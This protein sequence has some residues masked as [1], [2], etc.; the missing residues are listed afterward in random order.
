METRGPKTIHEQKLRIKSQSVNDGCQKTKPSRCFEDTNACPPCITTFSHVSVQWFLTADVVTSFCNAG[1]VP[2]RSGQVQTEPS[3]SGEH[4]CGQ[5]LGRLHPA[6]RNAFRTGL[7]DLKCLHEPVQHPHHPHRPYKPHHADRHL[8]TDLRAGQPG[9]SR[10]PES[11][12]E[13]VDQPLLMFVHRTRQR[14][15]TSTW[16]PVTDA[17]AVTRV[18]LY[19]ASLASCWKIHWNQKRSIILALVSN[20]LS[21]I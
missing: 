6:R 20:L 15:D 11:L 8:C 1:L 3:A 10:M 9:R 16:C 5:S 19:D 2:E 21:C 13:H 18:R 7:G 4:R 14:V 17:A 12:A